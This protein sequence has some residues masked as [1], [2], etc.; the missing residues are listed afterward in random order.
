MIELIDKDYKI[1]IIN[2]SK[3]LKEN[4][5]IIEKRDMCRYEFRYR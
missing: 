1:A 4:V 3:A 2:M 5:D